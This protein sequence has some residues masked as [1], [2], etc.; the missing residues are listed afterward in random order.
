MATMPTGN[1]KISLLKKGK[2]KMNGQRKKRKGEL[3]EL[4]MHVERLKGW[5][6]D[7]IIL[8]V[9]YCIDIGRLL[10]MGFEA[11]PY[12]GKP[13][14][15]VTPMIYSLSIESL[16]DIIMPKDHKVDNNSNSSSSNTCMSNNDN[17]CKWLHHDDVH[18]QYRA[19]PAQFYSLVMMYD[20][21]ND[22]IIVTG[23]D[24]NSFINWNDI[25]HNTSSTSTSSSSSTHPLA[26]MTISR[27][28]I[29]HTPLSGD[30]LH[31]SILMGGNHALNH[32]PSCAV[33]VYNIKTD[34]WSTLPDMINR[35]RS[36]LTAACAVDPRNGR[37][38]VFGGGTHDYDCLQAY[39]TVDY[40]DPITQRWSTLS[41]TMN[42]KRY[43]PAVIWLPNMNSFLITGGTPSS[44]G[45]SGLPYN[46]DDYDPIDG[47]HY[48]YEEYRRMEIYSPDTNTF[49]LLPS[50][51]SIPKHSGWPMHRVHLIDDRY[52]LLLYHTP[53]ASPGR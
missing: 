20:N 41:V 33:E 35:N 43:G 21:D 10:L 22:R 24:T 34:K 2:N 53:A 25:Q 52:L 12:D 28:N 46:E 8:V 19:A 44:H 40:Y 13:F 29:L 3:Q 48:E 26:S 17:K 4:L 49:T 6:H 14:Q 30:R 47:H 45:D 38:Y 7:L 27:Y 23:G 1:G 39:N 51:W 50:S 36:A 16:Y 18:L 15:T 37:I 42:R 9:D 11:P 5:P 32:S 31:E